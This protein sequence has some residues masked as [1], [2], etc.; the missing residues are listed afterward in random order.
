MPMIHLSYGLVLLSSSSV[1]LFSAHS[2][3][4]GDAADVGQVHFPVSA[5]APAQENFNRA[6][7][8]L[9]SFW[10]EQFDDAFSKVSSDDPLCGMAYWG[11]SMSYYHPLWTLPDPVALRK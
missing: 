6:V 3:L 11:L 8:M 5:T 4:A 10:Y 1:F 7:A 2:A 9:H